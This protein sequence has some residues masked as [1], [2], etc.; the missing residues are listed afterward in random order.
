[1][2]LP[3]WAWGEEQGI[4]PWWSGTSATARIGYNTPILLGLLIT[5]ST[6]H[7]IDER[8]VLVIEAVVKDGSGAI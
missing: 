3:V 7:N 8:E 6:G 2:Y 4:A 5:I 1:M